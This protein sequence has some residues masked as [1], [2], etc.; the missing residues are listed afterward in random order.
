MTTQRSSCGRHISLLVHGLSAV[1]PLATAI[2]LG[3]YNFCEGMTNVESAAVAG[4]S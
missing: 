2:P 4:D 1:V 3:I